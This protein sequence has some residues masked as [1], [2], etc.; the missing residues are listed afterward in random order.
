MRASRRA[1]STPVQPQIQ[2]PPLDPGDTFDGVD[3][4]PDVDTFAS[5]PS[6]R[7][8]TANGVVFTLGAQFIKI[9]IQIA[10]VVVLA[11][12]LLPGD[13]GLVAMV[14]AIVG[15]AEIFRE[16]GLS[17]AAIQAKTLSSGQR[18]NLV[19]LNGGAG[20]VMT[21]LIVVGAPLIALLYGR[22]ELVELA[23][24]LA[25]VFVLNGLATQYRADLNR[26]LEF[27]KLAIAEVVA[28]VV[29]L[30]AAIVV[31]ALGGRYWALVTQQLTTSVLVLIIVVVAA[32]WAPRWYDRTA[33]MRDLLRFGWQLAGSQLI[34]YIANNVDSVTIGTRLGAS[35][36]GLYN[37]AFQLLMTPLAQV[38]TP[39]TTV[40]LPILSRLRA[41]PDRANSFVRQGQLG[42][43]LTLV[44][45][46]GWVVGAADPVTAIFL[47]E[48]WVGVEP[49]LRLLAVAGVFQ[50][51]AFVGYWVYLSHGL[52]RQLLQYTLITSAIKIACVVGGSTFGLIGV[53]TGYA[54][55]PA[56]AWPLSFW[57]LSR[58]AP[59]EVRPLFVGAARIIALAVWIAG[60]TWAVST[61]ST[62]LGHW[63][64]LAL[65]VVAG[66]A[67]YGAAMII[68]AQRRD[69]LGVVALVREGMA[70]R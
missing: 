65:A 10:G 19:W 63:F 54:L 42:L 34:G 51:L 29:A 24:W 61:A 3:Q 70:R 11:R 12:L 1:P 23:R 16:F 43:G 58:S 15:I 49:I 40:A 56:L 62:G 30:T 2:P 25:P 66:A 69:V 39:T 53:A 20:L 17:A 41:T 5:E 8:R 64:Q 35:S 32:G 18:S 37:R 31:A 6:L 22:P 45:G 21:A 50:T 48:R 57:W 38:R 44:V 47:G 13:Y 28:A 4:G 26:R 46:L 14:T 67:A 27:R 36:L 52:T 60:V 7:R 9:I 55:A 68:P 59:I 33:P